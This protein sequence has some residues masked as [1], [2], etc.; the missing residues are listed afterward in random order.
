M[1]HRGFEVISS[2]KDKN[3][4]LPVRKTAHSAGYDIEA[5]ESVSVETGALALVATGLKAYMQADEY[6]GIHIRSSLGIKQRLLLAN[7]QGV[8]DSDYYNNSDNEGHI[9]IAILNMGDRTVTI[10]KGDRI[11][12]GIFYRY[13]TADEDFAEGTRSGGFGSTGR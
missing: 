4:K 8:I 9:I 11:A 5:A 1:R 13:L 12:Q 6:L 10:N 2:F 7:S 3:I